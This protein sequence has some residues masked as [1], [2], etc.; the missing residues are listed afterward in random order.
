M[1]F[2]I[3][4]AVLASG[5]ARVQSAISSRPTVPVLANILLTAKGDE[6][7]LN[8]TDLDLSLTTTLSCSVEREGSTTLPAKKF[9]SIVRQLP[10]APVTV[11]TDENQASSISCNTSF[12][13]ILGMS[14]AEFPLEK[15]LTEVRSFSLKN[16]QFRKMLE[17]ISYS[18]STDETRLVLNGIL[19]SIR[20]GSMT[21][22]AT[23][24]RRLALM[25][26]K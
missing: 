24:G 16:E 14:D 11:D 9:L 18:V 2:T 17:K 1:K 15:E 25:E 7:T 5:L 19:L 20:E 26:T 13:R 23:D 4:Q 10:S 22:V 8:S 12:F 3:D 6:L 21:A